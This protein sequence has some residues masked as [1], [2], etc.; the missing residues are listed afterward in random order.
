MNDLITIKSPEKQ[1]EKT[2]SPTQ[3]KF[4]RLTK[5]VQKNINAIKTWSVTHE[6]LRQDFAQNIIPLAQEIN[7]L[8]IQ[9]SNV[10]YD[11]RLTTINIADH[12]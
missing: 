6:K 2:L 3:K 10:N 7:Q 8:R 11:C 1:E 9:L 5:S 12:P 4:N